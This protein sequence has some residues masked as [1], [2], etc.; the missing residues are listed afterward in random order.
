MIAGSDS[1]GR[2]GGA[3]FHFC[4]DVVL[5]FFSFICTFVGGGGMLVGCVCVQNR[6]GGFEK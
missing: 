5:S 1:L 6:W 3:G 4:F 2:S